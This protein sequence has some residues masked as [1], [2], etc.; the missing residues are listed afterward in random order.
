MDIHYP[1]INAKVI[2]IRNLTQDLSESGKY[3]QQIFRMNMKNIYGYIRKDQNQL[4]TRWFVPLDSRLPK[5]FVYQQNNMSNVTMQ[6]MNEKF[7]IASYL[8]WE[9]TKNEPSVIL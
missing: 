5:M 2:E 7:V 3:N 4:Q 1:K 9:F 6:D 8:D